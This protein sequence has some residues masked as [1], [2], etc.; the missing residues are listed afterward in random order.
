MTHTFIFA[1]LNCRPWQFHGHILKLPTLAVS[2]PLFSTVKQLQNYKPEKRERKSDTEDPE[3]DKATKGDMAEKGK[4]M[5]KEFVEEG[6]DQDEPKSP[7]AEK[8]AEK[9]DNP[10]LERNWNKEIM[11]YR[12]ELEKEVLEDERNDNKNKMI[13]NFNQS[14]ELLKLCVNFFEENEPNWNKGQVERSRER[15]KKEE[16]KTRHV[17]NR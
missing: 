7:E 5:R 9:E 16:S 4:K 12:L 10:E 6:A 17:Q 2:W 3:D 8:A 13:D 14:W 1:V 15:E 11:E